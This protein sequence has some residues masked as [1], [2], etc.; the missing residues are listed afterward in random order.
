M[1]GR[2]TCPSSQPY[3]YVTRT[4]ALPVNLLF[5]MPWLL[6]YQ[7]ALFFTRSPVDNAAAASIRTLVGELGRN[8]S[9]LLTLGVAASLGAVVVIRAREATQDRGV[10]G[11]MLVEGLCYGALL[12]TVA[13]LMATR[14]PMER[15]VEL[16][17]ST[18]AGDT[19]LEMQVGIRDLG[20]AVGAGI[21]EELIFRG[22]LLAGLHAL[23]RYA[24]GTDRITAA[25]VSI[26][27]SA[28]LFSDY[29]HWGL[30]GEPYDA[31][32]FAFRFHAGILLGAVYLYRGL[33]IA[34]FAHGFY[35]VLV[36]LGR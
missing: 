15:W 16:A 24:V 2:L 8:G 33:G 5:L 29:H 35:D 12:G 22:V 30:T 27:L 26:V 20:L 14:L 18:A 25:V 32:I 23:L 7:L 21:F 11:G 6:V 3:D 9:M 19:M 28:Y 34:A 36:M 31:R 4:R 13:N 17:A 10:F 1:A